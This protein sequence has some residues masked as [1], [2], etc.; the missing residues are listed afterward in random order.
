MTN[1]NLKQLSKDELIE[2]CQMQEDAILARNR[3]VV[4]YREQG[5]TAMSMLTTYEKL[6]AELQDQITNYQYLLGEKMPTE[7][8]IQSTL[9]DMIGK[10]CKPEGT[11]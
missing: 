2:W 9:K 11:I 8:V 5:L 10:V 4:D 1:E 3:M 6:V 7:D